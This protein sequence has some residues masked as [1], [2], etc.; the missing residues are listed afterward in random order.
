MYIYIHVIY[1]HTLHLHTFIHTHNICLSRAPE[2][3]DTPS[4]I[5]GIKDLLIA[6]RS[7]PSNSSAEGRGAEG[8]GP[9]GQNF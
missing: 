8:V 9:T 3:Q 7:R 5:G 6:P 1:V 2:L 4:G